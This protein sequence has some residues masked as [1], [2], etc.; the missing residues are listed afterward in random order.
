MACSPYSLMIRWCLQRHHHA[1]AFRAAGENP[2]YLGTQNVAPGQRSVAAP[3]A[4]AWSWWKHH[5]VIRESCVIFEHFEIV[6]LQGMSLPKGLKL[7]WHLCFGE[8][9]RLGSI[10]GQVLS[11]AEVIET[12]QKK[13]G[14][15]SMACSAARLQTCS[16][17]SSKNHQTSDLYTRKNRLRK[18]TIFVAL[19]TAIRKC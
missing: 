19:Q 2:S 15:G 8:T 1:Y 6:A 9:P 3:V 11:A 13:P 12:L 14:P 4:M 5:W 17:V 7:T 18:L 16:K 10:L